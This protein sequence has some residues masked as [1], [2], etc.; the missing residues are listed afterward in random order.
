MNGFESNGED[1]LSK[2]IGRNDIQVHCNVL[3]NVIGEKTNNALR[4]EAP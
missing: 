1:E 4:P 3:V 2:Q